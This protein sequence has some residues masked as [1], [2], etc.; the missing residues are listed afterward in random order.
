MTDAA[1]QQQGKES[2]KKT[3]FIR[4]L[5]YGILALALGVA[6][7]TT[8]G[9]FFSGDLGDSREKIAVVEVEGIIV[10]SRDPIRLLSKYHK[11]DAIKGIILRIDSPG[12]MVGPSQ[13]IYEEV[14][15]IV[16]EG[17]K[18]I[19][20]SFG[21]LAASGGYYIAAPA[22]FIVSN[23]GTITGSIGVI[24]TFANSTELMGKIGIRPEV[25]KSGRFKDLGTSIRPMDLQDRKVLQ[26]VVDDVFQQFV[27]A[28]AEG[29]KMD[30]EEVKKLA[31][32]RIY[33]GRQAYKLKLVDHLGGLEETIAQLGKALG[34]VGR[35][36]VVMEKKKASLLDWALNSKTP[37]KLFDTIK[38]NPSPALQ[39]LWAPG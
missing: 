37:A 17:R 25:I 18:K 10:D 11:D 29:R 5:L 8:A 9:R 16:K 23:P 7:A 26:G 33:S 14:R 1:P 6:V 34:I 27:E 28:V 39:Y 2:R 15:K 3:S 38:P 12:G 19:Y 35:P 30:P 24:M 32:G 20:V 4:K 31:D 13:E 21:A 36:H 22:D